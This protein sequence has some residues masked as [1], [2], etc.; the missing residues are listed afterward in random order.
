MTVKLLPS[1]SPSIESA[2]LAFCEYVESPGMTRSQVV[3]ALLWYADQAERFG[4]DS[5]AASYR[6]S[7]RNTKI[8]VLPIPNPS[9]QQ[10]HASSIESR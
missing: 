6:D 9:S 5:T 4:L 8:G 1:D 7:A 10:D 2:H 3:K